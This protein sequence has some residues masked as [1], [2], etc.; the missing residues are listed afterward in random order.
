MKQILFASAA[1]IILAGNMAGDTVSSSAGSFSPFT[2]TFS[3]TTQQWINDWTDPSSAPAPL[4]WNNPSDDTGAGGSHMMNIGNVLTD[5]GGLAGTP[6][7][8]GTDKVTQDLTAANGADPIAFD[9]ISSGTAYDISL[10]FALSCLNTGNPTQG[11]VFGYYV[12]DTY[13]PLDAPRNTASPIDT[14]S[15]DPTVSGTSY[16][17]YATVCYAPGQ[18]ETY[19]TG[20]GNFGNVTGAAGWNHFALFQLASGSYVIG[21]EDSPSVSGENLGDFNDVVLE[22]QVTPEPGTLPI[23]GLGLAGLCFCVARKRRRI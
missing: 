19:T 14:Q 7:V 16:G 13:T 18:C 22:I 21:L 23:M 1:A 12:G 4:F 20:N 5:T 17:F 11:T 9:F 15:F 8:L 3:S 10:L 6:S 2:T